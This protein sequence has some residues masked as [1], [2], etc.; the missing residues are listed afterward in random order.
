MGDYTELVFAVEL[1]EDT[2]PDVIAIL[3]HMVNGTT[4]G[5]ETPN[6]PFFKTD[7]WMS[8]FL[9]DSYYFPGNTHSDF[10]YDTI[11]A[12]YFLTVRSNIKNYGQEIEKFLSWLAPYVLPH[13][14]AGGFAGYT[15]FEYDTTPTLIIFHPIRGLQ[16]L[17]WHD[18]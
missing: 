8:L 6:H 4:E 7:R 12:A 9:C 11:A 14:K 16:F 18:W 2:P 3:T 17:E 1:K 5:I 13:E 10:R 15:R